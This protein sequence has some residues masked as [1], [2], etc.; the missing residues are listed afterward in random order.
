MRILL[1]AVVLLSST[2]VANASSTVAV[3]DGVLTVVAAPG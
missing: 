3:Q 2:A 1:A